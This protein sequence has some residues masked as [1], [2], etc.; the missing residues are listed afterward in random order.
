MVRALASN[1]SRS[2]LPAPTSS[3]STI[4]QTIASLPP[5]V[6]T[7]VSRV[8]AG[9]AAGSGGRGGGVF[10]PGSVVS[11]A[12]VGGGGGGAGSSFREDV[13]SAVSDVTDRAQS[14]VQSV[15]WKTIL[16]WVVRFLSFSPLFLLCCFSLLQRLICPCVVGCASDSDHFCGAVLCHSCGLVVVSHIPAIP[17]F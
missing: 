8:S 1:A 2:A 4:S 14:A 17:F 5:A 10:S 12:G 6:R 11:A 9:A 15:P 13:S 7:G 16:I 3:S